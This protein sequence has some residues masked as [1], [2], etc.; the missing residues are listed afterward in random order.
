MGKLHEI[1]K[2]IDPQT[3]TKKIV[4]P[5]KIAEQTY[6]AKHLVPVSY[7]DFLEECGNYWRHLNIEYLRLNRDPFTDEYA[8]G[9]ALNY[10]D[11]AFH[12][13]GGLL[14]AYEKARTESFGIVKHGITEEF[15]GEA[16]NNYTGLMLTSMI[17]PFDYEELESLMNEYVRAFDIKLQSRSEFQRMIQNYEMILRSHVRHHAEM[18]LERAIGHN[19]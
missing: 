19:V 16:A 1:L 3:I 15:I 17:N 5:C 14:W 2:A 9:I 4:L 7:E 12:K 10:I 6:R 11:K 18:A 13:Y 8:G